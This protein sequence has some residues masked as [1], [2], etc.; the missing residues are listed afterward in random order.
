[1]HPEPTEVGPIGGGSREDHAFGLG[2]AS[3]PSVGLVRCVPAVADQV[4]DIRS[5]VTAFAAAHG[6]C[7]T[8]QA[9]IALAISE[10]CTNA[11]LHA[12]ADAPTPGPMSVE[13]FRDG[14]DL[15]VVVRDEGRGMTPRVDSPGLGMGLGIV[16]RLTR[17]LEISDQD[18]TPG[19]RVQMRFDLAADHHGSTGAVRR[20]AA[21]APT[22]P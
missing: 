14:G 16:R 13:A 8:A 18:V 2:R 4:A 10:A 6:A 3:A 5:A 7:A 19:T 1:M 22:S 12:Y 20:V 11:V 21:Q 15:V 17:R 9:D